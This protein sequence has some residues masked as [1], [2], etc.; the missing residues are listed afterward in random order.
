M[1]S[2]KW[3]GEIATLDEN[4]QLALRPERLVRH[5]LLFDQVV[6][7]S[8]RLREFKPLVSAFGFEGLMA[9]LRSG[10]LRVHCARLTIGRKKAY[11][12]CIPTRSPQ[13]RSVEPRRSTSE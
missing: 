4:N 1:L 6:I 7:Y 12:L 11:S 2:D 9:L 10:A 3:L 13:S 8:A 5:L